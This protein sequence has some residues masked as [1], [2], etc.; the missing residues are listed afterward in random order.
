MISDGV[1]S[2]WTRC[3]SWRFSDSSRR[4]LLLAASTAVALVY[5][6]IGRTF[7]WSGVGSS[8]GI[9]YAYIGNAWAHGALPYAHAWEMKP[10]GIFAVDAA[11]FLF[12]PYAFHAL[13]IVEGIVLFGAAITL[14]FVLR[15]WRCS[16]QSRCLGILLFAVASNFTFSHSN[17]A[18]VYLFWPAA[19]SMLC[20]TKA[21]SGSERK[22]MFAA[23][24]C[25][26]I[27]TLFKLTGLAAFLAQ[28]AYLVISLIFFRQYSFR[29]VGRLMVMSFAGIATVW[30]PV[31]TYFALH[32]IARPL[33]DA[34][35]IYPF[36]FSRA[37]PVSLSRYAAMT[38]TFLKPLYP[39][40]AIASIGCG[41]YVYEHLCSPRAAL[42]NMRRELNGRSAYLLAAL[43]MSADLLA[44]L[45]GNRSQ[46]Q[47]FWPLTMSTAAT[48]AVTYS[49]YIENV[50]SNVVRAAIVSLLAGPLV[51]TNFQTELP[52]FVHLVRY[53]HP[54]SDDA[55]FGHD[56][57][58]Q[59]QQLGDVAAYVKGLAQPH[60]TLFSAELRPWLFQMS[61]MNSPVYLL[62]LGFRKQLPVP[63]RQT[64]VK[65][66]L[67]ALKATPPTFIVTSS[68]RWSAPPDSLDQ[69]FSMWVSRQYACVKDFHLTN[70]AVYRVYR[71]AV[72]TASSRES[73]DTASST[74]LLFGQ[75]KAVT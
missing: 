12:R 1:S 53:G 43:W 51:I 41:A 73:V 54:L 31:V 40:I 18:E 55:E 8:D 22:W 17:L 61:G 72:P 4:N 32:G 24:I 64:F 20:F 68:D 74:H 50:A 7:T 39:M 42:P 66:A 16:Q 52:E 65:R 13:A 11:V 25:V 3:Y 9:L 19:M 26:G 23:G 29:S 33:I 38:F 70:G 47:Y 71:R 48:V 10:P 75:C 37:I 59:Q 2:I 6:A 46:T 15:E 69:E 5:I 67:T 36:L 35:F 63:Q 56:N 21:L 57:R 34:S 60:D 30:A 28:C 45:G 14:Y 62:D 44:A 49:V 27:A 58:S